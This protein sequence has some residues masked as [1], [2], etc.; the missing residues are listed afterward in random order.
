MSSVRIHG[1]DSLLGQAL[2]DRLERADIEQSHAAVGASADI[3]DT[4]VVCWDGAG[5]LP[6]SCD[7]LIRPASVESPPCTA[8]CELVLHDLYIP[9]GAGPWGPQE[10]EVALDRH[11]GMGSGDSLE[12]HPRWWLH[13]RDLLDAVVLLLHDPPLGV[14]HASGRRGWPHDV[15]LSELDMLW[16][17]LHAVRGSS[18]SAADLAP[19]ETRLEVVADRSSRPDLAPLH[20]ALQRAAADGWHPVIPLRVGLMECIAARLD[21]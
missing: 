5:T 19:A 20:S 10:I 11:Q 17:R 6:E 1:H 12:E 18:L 16:S 7:L 21:D 2:S 9:G 13:V 4:T 3:A 8:T 15:L 14:L